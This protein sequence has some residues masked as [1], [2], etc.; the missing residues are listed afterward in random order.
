MLLYTPINMFVSINFDHP[1]PPTYCSPFH[2]NSEFD[3]TFMYLSDTF[4]FFFHVVGY[5]NVLHYYM[6]NV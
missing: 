3:V 2:V 4:I 6:K 1:I 5:F